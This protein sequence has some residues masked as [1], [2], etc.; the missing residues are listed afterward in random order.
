MNSSVVYVKVISQLLSPLVSLL[1]H[2]LSIIVVICCYLPLVSLLLYPLSMVVIASPWCCWWFLLMS[3]I[4]HQLSSTCG[5]IHLGSNTLGLCLLGAWWC[6]A[7][8][9]TARC[10]RSGRVNSCW[11]SVEKADPD[12]NKSLTWGHDGRAGLRSTMRATEFH[13]CCWD[14]NSV[15]DHVRDRNSAR[16]IT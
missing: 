8:N 3:I 13:H 15:K 12:P 16:G 10:N 4:H 14:H 7:P 5:R 1:L 11:I 2:P 9:P 6:V